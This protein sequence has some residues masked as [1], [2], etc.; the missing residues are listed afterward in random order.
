LTYSALAAYR[1]VNE[2]ALSVG[3]LRLNIVEAENTFKEFLRSNLKLDENLN[4]IEG[5]IASGQ[6][7]I[8]DFVVYNP[9]NLPAVDPL[10]NYLDDVSIYCKI[11]VPLT[12]FF[13]GYFTDVL[14]PA[15]ITTDMP[16]L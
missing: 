13:A 5:S 1:D 4:P 3:E 12:P 2:E 6:V 8:N 7:I 14:I 16:N 15:A 9:E 11:T 10:G